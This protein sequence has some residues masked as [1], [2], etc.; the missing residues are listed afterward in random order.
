MNIINFKA[1]L[2][3]IH[4]NYLVYGPGIL[5]R[6]DRKHSTNAVESKV[7]QLH[8]LLDEQVL[9]KN[10]QVCRDCATVTILSLVN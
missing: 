1:G 7:L 2:P 8:H 3:V 4:N 9:T 5:A 10:R 6:K